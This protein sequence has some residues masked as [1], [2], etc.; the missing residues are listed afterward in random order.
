MRSRWWVGAIIA[1]MGLLL[2]GCSQRSDYPTQTA[3]ALQSRVLALTTSAHARDYAGA[4]LQLTRLEQADNA[5]LSTG[6][7]TRARHDAILAT[8]VQ[9]RADLNSLQVAARPVVT[10]TPQSQHHPKDGGDGKGKGNG[11]D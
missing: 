2:A 8:I 3:A 11:G 4:L 5:A 7:I 1:C 10:P 6:T 9:I